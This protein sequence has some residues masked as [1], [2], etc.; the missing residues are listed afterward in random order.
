MSVATR[1][2]LPLGENLAKDTAGTLSSMSVLSKVALEE[3]QIL[4][5]P[6]WLEETMS[7]PSRLKC[8]EVTGMEWARIAWRH[9]PVFTSHIRI[10]SSKDPETIRFDCGLKFTQKTKF[11]CPRRVFTCADSL[12]AARASQ[13]RSVRSSEAEQM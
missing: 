11:E 8:T 2:N 5:V 7:E 4:H 10:V 12:V 13:M 6:S 3:S 1:M 9:F